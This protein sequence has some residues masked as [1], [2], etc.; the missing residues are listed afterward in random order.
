[1]TNKRAD[2]LSDI[3]RLTSISNETIFNENT[4]SI[5]K[6]TLQ[7]R[8]DDNS[9]VIISH[10]CVP[11]EDHSRKLLVRIT[12]SLEEKLAKFSVGSDGPIL[13][14][15]LEKYFDE[16]EKDNKTLIITNK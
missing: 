8:I 3:D 12:K 5:F 1:M 4:S 14:A 10:A 6:F 7:D 2:L 9:P 13:V 11:K 15:V 16:L